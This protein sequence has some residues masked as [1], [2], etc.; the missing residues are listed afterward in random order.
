MNRTTQD[1]IWNYMMI[2]KY[3]GLNEYPLKYYIIAI[4]T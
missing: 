3:D 1:K 4:L 2:L